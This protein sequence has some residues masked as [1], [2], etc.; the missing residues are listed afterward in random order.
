MKRQ[1]AILSLRSNKFRVIAHRGL[2][3][4]EDENTIPAYLLARESGFIER[5]TDLQITADCYLVEMHDPK[6]DRTTNGHGWVK[7]MTFRQIRALQTKNGHQV[8]TPYESIEM[9]GTDFWHNFELKSPNTAAST[10]GMLKNFIGRGWSAENFEVSSFLHAEL[11]DFHL[12]LP[13]VRIGAL[14]AH[15]PLNTGFAQELDVHSIN[16][17]MDIID[18]DPGLVDEWHYGGFQVLVYAIDHYEDA[19]RMKEYGVDGIFS[20]YS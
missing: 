18:A 13:E 12:Y 6:V 7:E 2:S 1:Q 4:L 16:V 5:E 17:L 10:A 9:L 11:R 14:I 19:L 15:A 20:N 3:G 8:P